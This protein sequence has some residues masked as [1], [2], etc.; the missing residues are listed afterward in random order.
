MFHEG[1]VRKEEIMKTVKLLRRIQCAILRVKV[2]YEKLM[3]P[4]TCL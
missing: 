1:A 3:V 4:I 2:D